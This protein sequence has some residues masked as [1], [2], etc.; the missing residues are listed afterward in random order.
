MRNENPVPSWID[1]ALS[2]DM[3]HCYKLLMHSGSVLYPETDPSRT[4]SKW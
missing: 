4:K 3:S 1:R 2:L